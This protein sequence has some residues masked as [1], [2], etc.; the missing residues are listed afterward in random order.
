MSTLPI[1]T[2]RMGGSCRARS[3]YRISH[4]GRRPVMDWCVN[5]IEWCILNSAPPS[6]QGC[7]VGCPPQCLPLDPRLSCPC[8]PPLSPLMIAKTA[9]EHQVSA[10]CDICN[11]LLSHFLAPNHQSQHLHFRSYF[12][13]RSTMATVA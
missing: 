9:R 6:M 3:G 7:R 13:Q 5:A 11:G 8:C 2:F 4:K 1:L 12:H 10:F